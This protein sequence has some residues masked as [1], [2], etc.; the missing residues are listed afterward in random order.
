MSK[1]MA[2]I[3]LAYGVALAALSLFIRQI[4]PAFAKVILIT[5]MAGGGLCGLWGMVALAGHKGRAWTV[6]TMIAVSFVLLSQVVQVWMVSTD[7]TGLTGRLVLTLMFL[8]T[9]GTLVYVLHG[10]RPPEFYD[11][12]GAARRD[13]AS[14]GGDR[15]QSPGATRRP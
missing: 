5:G 7:A 13:N 2:S 6:L 3:I 12:G 4:A 9:V 10:E 8:M 14:S 11:S 1:K 15:A